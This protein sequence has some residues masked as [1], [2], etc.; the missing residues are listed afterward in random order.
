MDEGRQLGLFKGRRQRGTA[1][2]TPRENE[3][4]TRLVQLIDRWPAPGSKWIYTHIASGEKR[5]IV[6]AARLKRM[7][8]K[9]GW[10]DFIFVDEASRRVF[11]LELKRRG[12]QPS[13][14]QWRIALHL[15]S[16]G[17]EY[18]WTDDLREAIAWL[19]DLGVLRS[20]VS[21]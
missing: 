3:L 8:V 2:P 18:R 5:D 6:T 13:E 1:P 19:K 15:E 12:Q 14:E 11:F 21:T 20:M 10:P 16:A 9:R 17:C 4:H 7:G